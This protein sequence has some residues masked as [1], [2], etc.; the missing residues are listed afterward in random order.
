MN[1]KH[2]LIFMLLIYFVFPVF[3]QN[4]TAVQNAQ[5]AP[6]ATQEVTTDAD[7]AQ[8]VMLA[9]SSADYRVTAGDVYTLTYAAGNNPIIYVIVVDPSYRIRVSNMGVVNGAGKTFI[10]LKN[11]VE[12]IVTNNYPL[13]GVQLVLTQPAL[14]KVYVKGEVPVA[15]E[16]SVW[17]LSRL[18]SL[19]SEDPKTTK[20]SIIVGNEGSY[21]I[22][23]RDVSI[24]STNGQTRVYDLFKA[25]RMGDLSQDPY[26]RPGDEITFNRANRIITID[27]QVERPGTYQLLDGENINELINFY[28]SGFTPVADKTR[29]ELVRMVNSGDVTGNKIFLTE[30]DISGNYVLENRDVI[31]IPVITQL[32]KVMFVEGAVNN[33]SQML[34]NIAGSTMTADD[35][36]VSNRLVIQ[37]NMGETYASLVRRNMRWFTAV[38]DTANAYILRNDERIYINLNPMLYDAAYRGEVPV[39]ENDVLVIPFRQYFVTVAG[40]VVRPG[41]YPYIPDRSW[42]YYIALAGGFTVGRN[43]SQSIDITDVSGRKMRKTDAILPETVITANTNHPLYYWNQYMPVVTTILTLITT[44]F[45]IQ[46]YVN[47]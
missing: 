45:T 10:Q 22:S 24:R 15:E 21:L 3:A 26:L 41:R 36:S 35:A 18:S 39:L 27:G 46:A 42:E 44:I 17:A 34:S 31:T 16:I 25:R 6:T 9:R 43:T 20:T 11:E 19:I 13:S 47:R 30:R 23:L 28:C 5:E 14:F 40:A 29:I 38:S 33:A 4:V 2:F 1:N 12:T 37:F 7:L 8:K 32:Q